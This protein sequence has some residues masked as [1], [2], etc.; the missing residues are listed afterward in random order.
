MLRLRYRRKLKQVSKTVI[1]ISDPNV[2]E[3]YCLPSLLT[4]FQRLSLGDN[5]IV[6]FYEIIK[7][8]NNYS[9]L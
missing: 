2:H 7:E 9:S 6:V 4:K 5:V 8:Y 3:Q 1:D